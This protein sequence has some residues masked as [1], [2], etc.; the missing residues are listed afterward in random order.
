MRVSIDGADAWS[1]VISLVV[2][3]NFKSCC[4]IGK[5]RLLPVHVVFTVD[6]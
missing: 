5:G 2:G 3:C 4:L 1:E 6:A